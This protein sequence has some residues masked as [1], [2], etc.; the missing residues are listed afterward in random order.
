MGHAACRIS[1]F[2]F[3]TQ[4]AGKH[5]LPGLFSLWSPEIRGMKLSDCLGAP[6]TKCVR[7]SESILQGHVTLLT[8]SFS[9]PQKLGSSTID[10]CL[11]S[12]ESS[13]ICWKNGGH[14]CSTKWL[15]TYVLCFFIYTALYNLLREGGHCATLLALDLMLPS[16]IHGHRSHNGRGMS[17]MQYHTR[18]VRMCLEVANDISARS[19]EPRTQCPGPNGTAVQIEKCGPSCELSGKWNEFGKHIALSVPQSTE[20]YLSFPMMDFTNIGGT[21]IGYVYYWTVMNVKQ[22]LS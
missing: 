12:S 9:C 17:S 22:L 7:Q 15:R 13:V 8:S 18:G 19:L 4:G 3:L 1:R 6:L 5:T 20:K 21:V 11:L 14:L 16:S 10:F 2:S